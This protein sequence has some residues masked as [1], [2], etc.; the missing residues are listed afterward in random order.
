MLAFRKIIKPPK[1]ASRMVNQRGSSSHERDGNLNKRREAANKPD[2]IL[3]SQI[4][5]VPGVKNGNYRF[6]KR[7]YLI[8][9]SVSQSGSWFNQGA[10]LRRHVWPT[11]LKGD[12]PISREK[13]TASASPARSIPP[14]PAFPCLPTASLPRWCLLVSAGECAT[15]FTSITLCLASKQAPSR[16][17]EMYHHTELNFNFEFAFGSTKVRP[18]FFFN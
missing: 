2:E 13:S 6:I 8:S 9:T 17:W 5:E 11:V 4:S 3:I 1:L 15:A 12:G 14:A 10:R 18:F 7:L 16:C